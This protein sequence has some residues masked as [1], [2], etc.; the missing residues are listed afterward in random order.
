MALSFRLG[1]VD[2]KPT[3][4]VFVVESSK[5]FHFNYLLKECPSSKIFVFIL[6]ENS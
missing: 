6:D 1:H 2:C 5:I 4:V 3:T